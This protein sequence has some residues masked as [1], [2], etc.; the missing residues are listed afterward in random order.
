[1]ARKG[2]VVVTVS[3]RLGIF[4]FFSHPELTAESPQHA[5]GNYAL[6]DQTAALRWV[7]D[8]IAGFGGDPRKVTVA[9]ESAGSFSVSAQMASPTSK[10]LFARAIGES[11]A[12]FSTTIATPPRAET[13]Q[14]GVK[15]AEAVGAKSLADLRALSATELLELSGRQNL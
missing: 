3:H 6:M 8:N 1:M 9:G 7:H 13:E 4:G 11:G 14:N 2:I 10:D 15:F 5:S 12:F